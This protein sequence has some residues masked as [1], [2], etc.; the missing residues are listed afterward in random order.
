[1]LHNPHARPLYDESALSYPLGNEM[2]SDAELVAAVL[3]GDRKIYATLFH[4]HERSVLAAA[5]A[6]LRD[7]HLAQDVVQEAFVTAYEKLATLRSPASF[8]AWVRKIARHEALDVARDRRTRVTGN[9]PQA[10][11]DSSCDGDP[12]EA[13]RQL[14]RAIMSLPRHEQVALTLHYFEG[15]PVKAISEITGRPVG[16][17]TMQL[18]RARTRLR[19]LLKET[20]DDSIA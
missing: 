10:R 6:V 20:Y 4:R 13:Q 17:V 15:H 12:D 1:M 11:S 8:G 19:R 2:K 9:V 14:L 3:R 18:S 5:L 16:T 7:Y